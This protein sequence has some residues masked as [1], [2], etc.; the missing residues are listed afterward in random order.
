MFFLDPQK[1]IFH[2]DFEEYYPKCKDGAQ[3]DENPCF[4]QRKYSS[5][6]FQFL[7]AS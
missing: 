1:V 2:T 5:S 6:F 3:S 7:L 4:F